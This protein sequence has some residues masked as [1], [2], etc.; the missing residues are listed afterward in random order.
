MENLKSVQN[1]VHL[2]WVGQGIVIL[3]PFFRIVQNLGEN[4]KVAT[5]RK[6]WDKG[7]NL[8]AAYFIS[9]SNFGKC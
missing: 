2:F 1:T 9:I 8:G 7:E 3:F 4:A 6:G 5:K